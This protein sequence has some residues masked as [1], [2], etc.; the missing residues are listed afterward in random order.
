MLVFSSF[1]CPSGDSPLLIFSTS[2]WA[3]FSFHRSGPCYF[4]SFYLSPSLKS[5]SIIYRWEVMGDEDGIQ[6][7]PFPVPKQGLPIR[8]SSRKIKSMWG[9][10][11]G[12]DSRLEDGL[13]SLGQSP[14]ILFLVLQTFLLIS[15]SLSLWKSLFSCLVFLSVFSCSLIKRIQRMWN[16]A[17]G[18]LFRGRCFLHTCLRKKACLLFKYG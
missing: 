3:S 4:C 18:F 11:T 16:F 13:F 5:E 9:P 10:I 1:V 12:L 8:V 7:G 14:L 2:K 6:Y 17:I 15:L